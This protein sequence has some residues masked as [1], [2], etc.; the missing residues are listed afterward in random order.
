MIVQHVQVSDGGNALVTQASTAVLLPNPLL[1]T[2]L[3]TSAAT[4]KIISLWASWL[5]NWQS[6]TRK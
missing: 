5:S 1:V 4:P 2:A 3:S 6:G